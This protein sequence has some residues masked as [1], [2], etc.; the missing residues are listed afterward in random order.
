MINRFEQSFLNAVLRKLPDALRSFTKDDALAAYYSHPDWLVARWKKEFPQTYPRL[1][2]WNQLIPPTYIKIYDSKIEL[3]DGL[4]KTTWP[5]FY[6][7][8]SQISWKK[9]LYPLLNQGYAYIK[10]PST[11]ISPSTT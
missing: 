3:P 8:T 4:E 11:R 7:I 1:L 9:D 6:K 10:D 5:Q 2:E